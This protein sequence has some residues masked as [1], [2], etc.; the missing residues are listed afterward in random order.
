M[1]NWL[2]S[3]KTRFLPC[4]INASNFELNLLMRSRNS[5]NPKLMLGRE[6]AMDGAVADIGGR[7]LRLEESEGSNAELII[8]TVE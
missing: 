3:S 8:A 6:S 7:L 5:S 4:S 1:R 2:R